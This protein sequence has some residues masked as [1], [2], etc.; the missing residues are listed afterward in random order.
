[1]K[2]FTFLC[3]VSL[4]R[5]GSSVISVVQRSGATTTLSCLLPSTSEWESCLFHHED[6]SQD[7]V[8]TPEQTNQPCN[9]QNS[10][11]HITE[12]GLCQLVITGLSQV[13]PGVSASLRVDLL[14]LTL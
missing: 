2:I 6:S 12:D 9:I 10:Q 4:A 5:G 13:S 7:C 8:L 3:L 14:F 1:M 11:L